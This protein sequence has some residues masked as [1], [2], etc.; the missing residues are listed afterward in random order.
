[1]TPR[2]RSVSLGL[3]LISGIAPAGWV[4]AGPGPD[5]P[6]IERHDL[7][8]DP[9]PEDALVRLG[10]VRYRQDSPIY[11]IAWLPDGKKFVTDGEDSLLRVWDAAEGRV[12]LKIDPGVGVLEDFAL[13]SNG[14]LA[15]AVGMSIGP[16]GFLQNV[17]LCHLGT[18]RIED[19]GSWTAPAPL[20]H[21][22]AVCPRRRLVAIATPTDG[23]RL[24][25][26]WNGAEVRRLDTG[27]QK[28]EVLLFSGDGKRL[29]ATSEHRNFDT[30][31]RIFDLDGNRK[32][33]I[34]RAPT[35]GLDDLAFSPDS[36]TLAVSHRDNSI[37]LYDIDAGKEAPLENL[38]SGRFGY[39]ADGRLLAGVDFR[40]TVE[41]FDPPARKLVTSS[42]S[43]MGRASEAAL[44]PDGRTLLSVGQN[45]VLHA[46]EIGARRDRYAMPD[47]HAGPIGSIAVGEGGRTILT[48]GQDGTI[49]LWDA[50]TGK[51][52]RKHALGLDNINATAVSPDSRRVAAVAWLGPR[53]AIWDLPVHGEPLV[54][55][56]GDRLGGDRPLALHF[57]DAN[58]LLVLDALG[59][60][61][62]FD[63]PRRDVTPGIALQFTNPEREFDDD[64][65]IAPMMTSPDLSQAIFLP[66]GKRV[67][68]R[69]FF[70]GLH[71]HDLATGK[72]IR[73]FGDANQFAVSPNGRTLAIADDDLPLQGGKIKRLSHYARSGPRSGFEPIAVSSEI[74]TVE[75]ETGRVLQRIRVEG[76]AAWTLAFSPDGKTLA[77]T[78]GWE[79]GEIQL[80]DVA[81]GRRIRAIAS[82]PTRTPALAFTPDSTRLVTG[83]ADGSALVWNLRPAP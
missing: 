13:A 57:L 82:P 10:T 62:R 67:M 81:T 19:R 83:M 34:F 74:R 28:V 77:V 40:G 32:P 33:K 47:A 49:R 59:R 56:Y 1:M 53:V 51:P 4:A 38:L 7:Y 70:T 78:S 80:F 65:R 37:I 71:L 27:G 73:R 41:V 45:Q 54:L 17:S 42:P 9:I 61:F 44:S 68:C 36:R 16:G 14:R 60:T 31:L 24:L 26:A 39:S 6:I 58:T 76:S 15:M 69:G 66:D 75:V 48:G 64:A 72:M 50:A 79:S 55:S 21:P 52:G 43:T 3:L 63:I 18:G 46:W 12:V 11:R 29:C 23:I 25:D 30:T 20:I 8:G 2:L 22:I 5:A 35:S